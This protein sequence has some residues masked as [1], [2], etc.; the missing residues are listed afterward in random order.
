MAQSSTPNGD[1]GRPAPRPQTSGS[2]KQAP[3]P[4]PIFSDYASI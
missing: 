4:R 2:G 1:K 3:K